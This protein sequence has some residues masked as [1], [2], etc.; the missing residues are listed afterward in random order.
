M[1]K[2]IIANWKMNPASVRAARRLFGAIKK[3]RGLETVVAPPLIYLPFF[4]PSSSLKLGAQDASFKE[5]GGAF[6][7]EVSPKMLKNLGVSYVLV[8]HS[9]RREH[10][11]ETAELIHQKLNTVLAR[12]LK[13]VLC[14]GERERKHDSFPPLVRE[15]LQGALKGL[16]RRFASRVIIAYE[17][18]GAIGSGKPDT[19][20]N[21]FQ[22]AIFIRR[23][24]LDIWGRKAALRIPIL[25][26]GSV[27]SQNAALFLRVKGVSGLLVGGLSLNPREFNKILD[28]A[29]KS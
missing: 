18:L 27:N 23:T 8:G 25:Y 10:L 24:I 17:P 11:G 12:G 7:G 28:A 4:K 22:M 6:T 5:G 26:G 13:A 1:K 3:K 19:P 2:I 9:E 15:E 20:L 29:K 14:V 21:I 16:P